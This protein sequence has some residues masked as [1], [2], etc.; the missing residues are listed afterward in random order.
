[1]VAMQTKAERPL[2]RLNEAIAE[3]MDWLEAGRK[4]GKWHKSTDPGRFFSK[5][6]DPEFKRKFASLWGEFAAAIQA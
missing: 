5:E 1:M 3:L 2:V 4:A 6:I